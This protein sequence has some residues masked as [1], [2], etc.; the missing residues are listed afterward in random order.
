VPE[1]E[2]NYTSIL[3]VEDGGEYVRS[4]MGGN[5]GEIKV[6]RHNKWS[7]KSIP[8]NERTKENYL[9]NFEGIM[10]TTNPQ[11]GLMKRILPEFPRS[12]D[13]LYSIEYTPIRG[14]NS[15]KV[16]RE[17]I[18]GQGLVLWLKTTATSDGKT[19]TK[20]MRPTN[21][22]TDENLYQGIAKEGG[23]KFQNGKKPERLIERILALHTKPGD[24][25]LDFFLGSGTTAAV[26]HK[27]GRRYI[28]IEQIN[29]GENDSTQRMKNV[30]EGD[31]SGI[32]KAYKWKGGGEYVYL[33]LAERNFDLAKRISESRTHADLLSIWEEL[34]ATPY[35]AY[36]VDI[37]KFNENAQDFGSLTIDEAKAVLFEALDKNAIYIN[38]SE[39]E[40]ST[41]G[42]SPQEI[43]LTRKF[44]GL[45]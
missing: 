10:R 23:V 39:L 40:D 1:D 21:A 9:S 24:L 34:S 13:E 12:K 29:Y 3:E 36:K 41:N 5:V 43:K 37:T 17:H 15:G 32:S 33:E 14:R 22:W 35:L 7:L 6:F 42:L 28:G 38:V 2:S 44:Y 31:S 8:K 45:S 11:G 30:L 25:V 4:I 26:A 16:V 18:L 27:M 20:L 19:I